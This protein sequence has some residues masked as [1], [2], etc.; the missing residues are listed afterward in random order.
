GR[1]GP[2][3]PLQARR[4]AP[5]ED[6]PA[7]LSHPARDRQRPADGREFA[8]RARADARAGAAQ[9]GATRSLVE[10]P[11]GGA[12]RMSPA[13]E[14]AAA[15]GLRFAATR[16]RLP[17]RDL[18]ALLPMQYARRHLVLPIALEPQGLDVAVADPM[19]LGPLD[20]LRLLYGARVRPLVVPA[21]VLR[22][23]IA[24]AYDAAAA[25]ASEDGSSLGTRLA[26][27]AT[28]RDDAEPPDLR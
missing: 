27:D 18:L 14:P 12:R 11:G 15:C 6:Q 13:R 17:S 2:G 26:L 7:R 25:A 3:Q 28:P 21:D 20:D 9:P 23:A 5:R 1:P 4:H 24:R 10:G 16:P 22:D 8:A 19:A